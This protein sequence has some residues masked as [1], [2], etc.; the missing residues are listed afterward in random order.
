L[1]NQNKLEDALV[2]YDLAQKAFSA[3]LGPKH[4][5]T[6]SCHFNMA[7]V[8]RELGDREAAAAEVGAARSIWATALGPEHPHTK[9]AA[10]YVDELN[11]M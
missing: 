7:L 3:S 10:Q 6:G 11:D 5:H 9:M 2:E 1:A 4:A 8:H